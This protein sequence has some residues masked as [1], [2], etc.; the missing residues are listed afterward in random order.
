[1]RNRTK[2]VLFIFLIGT[3][4]AG[5][6]I[7]GNSDPDPLSPSALETERAFSDLAV[8]ATVSA[9]E[10]AASQGNNAGAAQPTASNGGA[11][12]SAPTSASGN[13]G[14]SS[15]PPALSVTTATNCRTGPGISYKINGTVAIST[16]Y[17]VIGQPS[18]SGL[19]YLIINNPS[20][21]GNCW[22]WL[23]Y[24]SVNGDVSGLP[25]IDTPP[26]PLG[27]ISGFVWVES[28]DD[29]APIAPDCNFPGGSLPEGNGTYDGE[30]GLGGVEIDLYTGSCSN[31][32]FKASK[33]TSSDGEFFFDGL[34]AGE[35]CVFANSNGIISSYGGQFTY[36]YT[37]EFEASLFGT[38]NAGQNSSNWIFGWD[39]Y[40][41]V[42]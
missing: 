23:E 18:Q 16:S 27:S 12:T 34:E 29:V 40:D 10:L 22:A 2:T 20:G 31:P 26:I 24:A 32:T 17:D 5:C 39:F 11:L 35:Y 7:F 9:I 1:M 13:S 30:M 6:G 19:P 25:K 14:A 38:L 3:L 28:C 37:D 33:T 41:Q 15:G 21:S 42:H 4:I 36:P 8:A